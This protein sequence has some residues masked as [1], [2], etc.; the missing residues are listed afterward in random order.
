MQAEYATD[1][2]FKKQDD[3]Q[4]IYSE[5]MTTA[6]HAVK[7]ENIATFLGHK[8]DVGIKAKLEIITMYALKAVA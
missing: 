6:I 2:V 4:Q 5:L 8:L 3:L 1:I 7:P